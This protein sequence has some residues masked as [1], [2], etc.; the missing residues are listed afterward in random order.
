[1]GNG[2][3]IRSCQQVK[4]SMRP[5]PFGL[6]EPC[7]HRLVGREENRDLATGQLLS[8]LCA[9]LAEEFA[10]YD[11]DRG[12][13]CPEE[14]AKVR[15]MLD[16]RLGV[17]V[18][19]KDDALGLIVIEVDVVLQ[20]AGVL[21]PHDLHGLSGQAL[22]LLDLALVKL[23]PSDTPKLT[24]CSGLQSSALLGSARSVARARV[25]PI[26]V[27][28]LTAGQSTGGARRAPRVGYV[29]ATPD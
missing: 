20:R 15:S 1:M 16:G 21:S 18:P 9:R 6:C 17:P 19:L 5:G 13:D 22:E 4:V 11:G 26:M 3:R 28:G 10:M 12:K 27:T 23:E 2:P 25:L 8:Q 24:H 14:V 29:Q 7:L